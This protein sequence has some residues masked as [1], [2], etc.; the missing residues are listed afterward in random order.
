MPAVLNASPLLGYGAKSAW[1]KLSFVFTIAA[2]LFVSA[3]SAQSAE[4]TIAVLGDSLVKGFGLPAEDGFVPQLGTWLS[5]NGYEATLINAGVSGDTTAGGASRID[6]T[7]TPDVQ[8][9]VVSLGGNDVLRGISPDVSAENLD[10]ILSAIATKGLP[11]LLIGIEVPNN[12]GA[13]YKSEF[14]AIYPRLAD[15]YGTLYYPNFLQSLVN[16]TDIST[17]LSTYFQSDGIHPNAA[18][19]NAIVSDIGPIIGQLVEQAATQ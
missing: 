18:G 2:A 7:L 3:A 15:Q 17:V 9:V 4:T 11:V 19:V 10:K 12:Y 1:C 8:G 16:G 14:E 13:D 6:W 5:E